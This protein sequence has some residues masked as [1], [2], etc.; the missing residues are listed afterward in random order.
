MSEPQLR[1]S[2][3]H[4][5]TLPPLPS[6]CVGPTPALSQA[7][8]QLAHEN[9]RIQCIRALYRICCQYGN[10]VTIEHLILLPDAAYQWILSYFPDVLAEQAETPSDHLVSGVLYI[11]DG[12]SGVGEV[13]LAPKAW[14]SSVVRDVTKRR[15]LNLPT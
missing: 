13:D 2:S 15:P 5:G 12:K 10:D 6:E 9:T 7:L 3:I 14:A 1:D 11:A 8:Y 4:G